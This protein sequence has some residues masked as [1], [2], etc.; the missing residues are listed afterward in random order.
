ML[1]GEIEA[2]RRARQDAQ[3]SRDRQNAIDQKERDLGTA[4]AQVTTPVAPRNAQATPVIASKPTSP[5]PGTTPTGPGNAPIQDETSTAISDAPT[6]SPS[7][8]EWKRRR[9]MDGVDNQHIDAIMEMTGL[10]KVKE[11]VLAIKDKIDMSAR[12]DTSV[13]DERFHMVLL[14]NPGTGNDHKY[15]MS[16]F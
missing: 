3:L 11:Q 8:D 7:R 13:R 12:Q 14:G 6:S 16:G 1:D 10:E 2:L 4:R 9:M 15:L 5:E